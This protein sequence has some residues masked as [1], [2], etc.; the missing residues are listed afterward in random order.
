M[1]FLGEYYI[2]GRGLTLALEM[3]DGDPTLKVGDLFPYNGKQY[4]I[5]G[6][7]M[8]WLLMSPPILSK[9]IGLN[10]SEVKD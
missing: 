5:R 9:K 1:K 4:R 3:E 10:L 7:E 8:A 6:I 2:I